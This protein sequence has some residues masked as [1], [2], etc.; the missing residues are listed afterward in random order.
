MAAAAPAALHGQRRGDDRPLQRRADRA[1]LG[2]ARGEPAGEAVAG[3]HGVDRGDRPDRAPTTACPSAETTTA[4]WRPRVTTTAPGPG[5]D[6]SRALAAARGGVV[7]GR[8]GRPRRPRARVSTVPAT[9]SASSVSF[10]TSTSTSAHRS[11]ATGRKGAWFTIVVAP[12]TRAGL[13]GSH[14]RRR[15]DLGLGEHHVG[16]AEPE[17]RQ[18]RHHLAARVAVGPGRHDDRVGPLAAHGDERG[19]RGGGDRRHRGH[20][21]AVGPGD[22]A[23]PASVVVV[24]DRPDH[25]HRHPGTGARPRPG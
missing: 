24:A 14:H 15:R 11:S 22:L 7:R 2:D 12:A 9:S 23:Q 25:H 10:T 6:A 3:P 19:A 20:V 4:P 1:A 17:R 8:R 21:D 18:R 16:G 13:Q 5:R